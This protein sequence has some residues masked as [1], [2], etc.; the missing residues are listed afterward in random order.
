MKDKE[1]TPEE[2]VEYLKDTGAPS[3]LLDTERLRTNYPPLTEDEKSEYIKHSI[4]NFRKIIA[5]EYLLSCFYR[6]GHGVNS[7]FAFRHDN[8]VIAVDEEVIE[9]LLIHQIDNLILSKRPG[10]GYQA[11][12]R[13]YMANDQYEKE[14]GHKWMQD[15]IDS[16][17]A[18]GTSLLTKPV[19]NTAIH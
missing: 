7:T 18:K 17:F 14:T 8:N 19:S 12:W 6:F 13:F 10:D 15:F 3:F 11:L 9:T 5:G 16:I 2:I 4:K 1:M